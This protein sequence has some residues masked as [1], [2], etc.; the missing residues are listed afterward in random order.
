MLLFFFCFVSHFRFSHISG[1]TLVGLPTEIYSNGTQYVVFVIAAVLVRQQQQQR[2]T[3]IQR[4]D[5]FFLSNLNCF[6]YVHA[7]LGL[8]LA[9]VFLPLYHNLGVT[10]SFEYLERRF[11]RRIRLL[12]GIV[13]TIKH[14]LFI[15]VVIYVPAL[16]FS[17]GKCQDQRKKNHF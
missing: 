8:A 13:Y 11:D 6:V 17:Q 7:Q 16:V 9:Y 12:A 3:E 15:P 2:L 1:Q 14:L 10:S 5:F 4:F